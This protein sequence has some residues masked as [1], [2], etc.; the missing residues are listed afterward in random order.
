MRLRK[1]AMCGYTHDNSGPLAEHG[2]WSVVC[3]QCGQRAPIRSRRRDAARIW[4]TQ[5]ALITQAKEANRN[6]DYTR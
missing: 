4:N 1:C 2:C 6:P 5:Q 3:Y